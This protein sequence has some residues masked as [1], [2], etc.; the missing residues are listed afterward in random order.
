MSKTIALAAAVATLLPVAQAQASQGVSF[1]AHGRLTVGG[2]DIAEIVKSAGADSLFA[3]PGAN[4]GCDDP[5]AGPGA[6]LGCDDPM[7]GPGANLGCDDPMAGPGAN[8]GCD[9]PMAGPGA[10][11]GCDDP[12]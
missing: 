5:M 11:L 1:D 12:A 3:G 6:N 8:L 10:N 7:A 4:L 9:D 2:L